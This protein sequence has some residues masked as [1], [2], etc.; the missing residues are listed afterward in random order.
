VNLP[1][2][3]QA[4]QSTVAATADAAER[5][6]FWPDSWFGRFWVLFGLGAQGMFTARFLVQWIASERRGRSH[7]PLNFWYLSLAGATMLFVYA[8]VWKRDLVVCLGQTT[9]FVVYIRNIILIFRE[10]RAEDREPAEQV[11]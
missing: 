3:A 8:A 7:V 4:V 11:S 5:A 9:G 2:L 10:R 6:S 1:L